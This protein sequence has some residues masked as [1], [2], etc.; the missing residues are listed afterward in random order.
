[1]SNLTLETYPDLR[2][3]TRSVSEEFQTR[4]TSYME[5]VNAH[6]RPGAVFGSYVTTG[7]AKGTGNQ[8]NPNKASGAFSQFIAFFKTIGAAS[9][10]N[11]EP[12]LPDV[13]EINYAL[14]VVNRFSYQHSISTPSG[15][16]RLTVTAP[17]RFVL[18]YPGYP[19]N[20][21]RSLV[22]SRPAKDKLAEFALHYAVLNFL[23]TQNQ[24]L[25][26]LFE[27]LRFP[28]RTERFDEFGPLPITMITAPSGSVRPSDQ[29]LARI[30]R[31]SGADAVEELAEVESWD[32][33]PDPVAAR[34]REEAAK[35]SIAVGVPG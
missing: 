31:L 15:E 2:D 21:L 14:P 16:R 32:R 29:L 26:R 18:T 13:L 25:L 10:F 7:A 12:Q 17:F 24:R 19:F 22:G 23:V 9:P 5:T 30:C 35:F 8:E 4:I 11:L 27:D 6:F 1:M 3:L 34:L 20:E 33:L 28:I